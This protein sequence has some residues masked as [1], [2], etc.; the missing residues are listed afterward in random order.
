[1]RLHLMVMVLSKLPLHFILKKQESVRF[2]GIPET[3]E[4][5]LEFWTYMYTLE[6]STSYEFESNFMYPTFHD[7]MH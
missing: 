7:L 1:M 6:F 4:Y 3:F 5:T 2:L